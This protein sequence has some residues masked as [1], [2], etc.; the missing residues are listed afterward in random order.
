MAG[1][2]CLCLCGLFWFRLFWFR[3]FCS[4]WFL[5]SL[6][7]TN[8]VILIYDDVAFCFPLNF[9]SIDLCGQD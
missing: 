1:Y 3:L 7:C 6:V 9:L 8:T 5:F 2:R 4:T